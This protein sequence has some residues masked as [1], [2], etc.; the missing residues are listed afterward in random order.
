MQVMVTTV[1]LL[2]GGCWTVLLLNKVLLC[3]RIKGLLDVTEAQSL[4]GRWLRFLP[5]FLLHE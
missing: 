2:S 1:H 5:L 3:Y 4:T